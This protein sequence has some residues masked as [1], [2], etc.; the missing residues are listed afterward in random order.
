M[1]NDGYKNL[2]KTEE[3]KRLLK[4]ILIKIRNMQIRSI[5]ELKEIVIQFLQKNKIDK[6]LSKKNLKELIKRLTDE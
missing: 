5:E 4:E 2:D 1:R 3:V 6:N